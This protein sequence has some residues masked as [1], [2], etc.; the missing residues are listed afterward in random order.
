MAFSR[1]ILTSLKSSWASCARLPP[2]CIVT[3][4][5]CL[6]NHC[7]HTLRSPANVMLRVWSPRLAGL[8]LLILL[9]AVLLGC[10]EELP[11]YPPAYREYAYVTNGKSNEVSVIDTLTFKGVK[12]IRVGES[13]TGIAA[14]PNKNE[15][16]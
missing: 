7:V 4:L 8:A 1:S 12:R 13:P 3:C 2:C 10:T 6:H 11:N 14:N 5:A 9:S 16:Y 15:I